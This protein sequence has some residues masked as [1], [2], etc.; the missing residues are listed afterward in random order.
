[1]EK[2]RILGIAPFDSIRISMEH[3]VQDEFPEVQLDAY[4]GDLEDGL[5][6]VQTVHSQD[7][8]V[9]ISRGGT[10]ALLKKSVSIPVVEINFS[11]YDILRTIKM[12]ENYA[13]LYA[14]VG[15]PS[16]TEPAHI[17]CDLL[18]YNTDIITVHNATEARSALK[19][20]K[21]GNYNTVVCDN[22][23]HQIARELGYSAFLIT[24]GSESLHD[25]FEHAIEI[26]Q[27]Y[28]TLHRE[29]AFLC[30]A[31]T[32]SHSNITVFDSH[33]A[34][35]YTLGEKP[36]ETTL[37]YFR[38]HIR[39]LDSSTRRYLYIDNNMYLQ[40]TAQAKLI[41]GEQYYIFQYMHTVLTR[42]AI[43]TGIHFYEKNEVTHLFQDSF[44][45]ISGAIRPLE[46]RIAALAVS[47]HPVLIAGEPGT[48]KSQIAKALYLNS[49]FADGP[50][51]VIDCTALNERGWDF[52]LNS[53]S[54]PL[55]ENRI[56]VY[57]KDIEKLSY[58]KRQELLYYCSQ[59]N[60]SNRVFLIFSATNADSNTLPV[61]LQKFAADMGCIL[62][63][64]TP[65][66]SR[67]DEIPL[68]AN[69]YLNSLN[70]AFGKQI[71]GFAPNAMEQL[72]H[73]EWPDN[74]TQFKK[75]ITELTSI[76]SSSYILSDSVADVLLKERTLHRSSS[77]ISSQSP[78]AGITL[79]DAIHTAIQQALDACGGNQTQ[80]AKRLGISRSTLWRHLGGS[81]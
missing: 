4:T 21:S 57:F 8:D 62:M 77:D 23:T 27:S 68:L 31:A 54:S 12:V 74:F 30:S 3:I 43:N 10:A 75:V 67:S 42:K 5:K 13:N 15:F 48:G 71:V 69:L 29:L 52:L 7:Y 41:S 79:N 59:I 34:I 76:A 45:S 18:R 44:L 16:I 63:L 2:V 6:I 1:M 49:I 17:L 37:Y 36:A 22:I 73:Y 9:I 38:Q 50:F 26:A 25:A 11:V 53:S 33:K 24:S 47:G 55:L 35:C 46:K 80:A 39:D 58:S 66:R 72:L 61:D 19:R 32:Q 81:R 65:L 78:A 14:I 64:T 51:T 28:R 56:A 40:V 60:L 20:L 70:V